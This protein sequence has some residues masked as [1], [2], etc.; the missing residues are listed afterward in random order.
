MPVLWRFKCYVSASGTDEM[1]ASYDGKGRQ[2]QNRF[3]SR[4]TML[5]QLPYAQWNEKLYKHLRGDCAGLSE[6]RFE[7][8]GVQ[9]RPLGF[10]SAEAEFTLLFWAQEVN[11]RWV[12][13]SACEIA[14]RRKNE[15]L[16]SEDRAHALWF[17][18]E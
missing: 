9:Q 6:I 3:R 15:V 2:A 1:R 12:P 8:D 7:A 17:A 13:L 4:L 10:R 16:E 14:L 5:A 18:L 11:D